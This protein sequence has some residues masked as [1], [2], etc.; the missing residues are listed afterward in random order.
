MT[1]QLFAI[2][3][4]MTGA[5]RFHGPDVSAEDAKRLTGLLARVADF[6]ADG[7]WHTLPEIARAV[8]GMEASVSARLRQ[9][10]N[11]HGWTVE[12]RRT[13]KPGIFEYRGS[14]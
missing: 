9:L 11:D 7:R 4:S 10:R 13:D 6:M 14:K 3:R 1:E 12:R 5:L 2:E 8:N